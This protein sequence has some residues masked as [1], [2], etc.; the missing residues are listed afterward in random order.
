MLVFEEFAPVMLFDGSLA[1]VA[2]GVVLVGDV[3]IVVSAGGLLV[4]PGVD[5]GPIGPVVPGVVIGPGV[6][7]GPTVPVVPTV[8]VGPGVVVGPTV[9]V[10][11]RVIGRSVVKLNATVMIETASRRRSGRWCLLFMV[12]LLIPPL[13]RSKG[14]PLDPHER[15]TWLVC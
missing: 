8:P 12:S 9:G 7:V 1:L 10:S 5:V 6:D 11:A 2:V 3:V 15:Q 13:L 4:G 14:R